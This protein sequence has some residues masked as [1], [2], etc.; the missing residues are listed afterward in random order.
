MGK[1]LRNYDVSSSQLLGK[2][3]RSLTLIFSVWLKKTEKGNALLKG[4]V[5]CVQMVGS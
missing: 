1:L 4:C 2:I 3:L 5:I